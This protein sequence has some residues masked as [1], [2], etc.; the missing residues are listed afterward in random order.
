MFHSQRAS[1]LAVVGES[2]EVK[3]VTWWPRLTSSSASKY[4]MH[5]TPP[6]EAGATRAHKGGIRATRKRREGLSTPGR[7]RAPQSVSVRD[8]ARADENRC[9]RDLCPLES[10]KRQAGVK[11]LYATLSLRRVAPHCR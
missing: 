3:T 9:G 2:L 7:S 5:S 4:T 1:T 8:D 10:G 11:S 6:C